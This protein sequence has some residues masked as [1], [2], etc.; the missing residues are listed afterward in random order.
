MCVC[1]AASYRLLRQPPPDT[2][3]EELLRTLREDIAVGL[4]DIFADLRTRC[5]PL[6]IE[7]HYEPGRVALWTLLA[8]RPA[9][10]LFASVWINNITL[11]TF[12]LTTGIFVRD[13]I[14]VIIIIQFGGNLFP[15]YSVFVR[16]KY[17]RFRY[18]YRE[19]RPYHY[20]S[21]YYY[22]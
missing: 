1:Q 17:I 3:V 9:E 5:N 4:S 2:A 15:Y 8:V 21:R 20:R 16:L 14:F 22:R 6:P 7:S 12:G 13:R 10:N 11:T 18:R 19:L